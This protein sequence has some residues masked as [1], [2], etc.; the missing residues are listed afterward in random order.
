MDALDPGIPQC[1]LARNECRAYVFR[2]ERKQRQREGGF[3]AD[4][5]NVRR[6]TRIT[7]WW[8]EAT[9]VVTDGTVLFR[10]HG[11]QAQIDLVERSI[12]PLGP[13]QPAGEVAGSLLRH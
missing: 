3:F 9:V 4:F 6:M 10:N 5:F 2:F 7:G 8:F 11:G 1:I 13:L 12:N